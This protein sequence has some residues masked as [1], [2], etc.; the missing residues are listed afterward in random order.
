MSPEE[1]LIYGVSNYADVGMW[2]DIFKSVLSLCFRTG[3]KARGS[4]II[5]HEAWSLMSCMNLGQVP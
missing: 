3:E 2:N 4:E 1:P 5:R